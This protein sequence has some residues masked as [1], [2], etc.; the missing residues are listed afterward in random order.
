ML[1]RNQIL[2]YFVTGRPISLNSTIYVDVMNEM[3]HLENVLTKNV[4]NK[5]SV[6]EWRI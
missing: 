6:F 3:N 2:K 5:V 4:V 1:H